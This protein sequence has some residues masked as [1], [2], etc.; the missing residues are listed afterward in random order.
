MNRRTSLKIASLVLFVQ[1]FIEILG[2]LMMPFAHE[3]LLTGFQDKK[4]F[5]DGDQRYLWC[6]KVNCRL[7][8]MVH[9]KVGDCFWHGIKHNNNDC[10]PLNLPVWHYGLTISCYGFSLPVVRIVW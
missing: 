1:G 7:L 5:L 3:V 8:N 2:A 6:I 10:S 4:L 9:E